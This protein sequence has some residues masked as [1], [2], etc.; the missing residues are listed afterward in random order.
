MQ[1]LYSEV[2]HREW[3][4]ARRKALW[5]QLRSSLSSKKIELIDFG[6]LSQR[7]DLGNAAYQGVQKIRVAKIMGSVGRYH[8][9]VQAFLPTTENMRHRWEKIATLYLD[10]SSRGLPPI[11]VYQVGDSYFVSD[12][13]HRVSVARQLGLKEL[14]AHVWEYP[15]PVAGLAPGV[16]IDSL[17]IE[18]ERRE[19]L[20]KTHLDELRPG[21]NIR[22][23]A[24]GGYPDML[25]QMVHYQQVLSLIDETEVSYEQ[26]VTA[27][28]DMI[29]KS[30]V[31]LIENAGVLNIFPRRTAAD[32]FIWARQHHRELEEQYGQAV[33]MA[34]AVKDIR[35]QK[36]SPAVIRFWHSF[37]DWL[38][39]RLG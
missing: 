8:D 29:Y 1:D 13:N 26:A 6:Q 35:K 7:F 37:G 23:T 25:N 32:F 3:N 33:L 38:K 2:A 17:L 31:L 21:H 18:A 36:R 30:T 27:W 11:E 39:R 22:L 20:E 24:P 15:Q 12:G 14:E 5:L 4:Q 16:D 28:Y 34:D 10:P 9:F 19:F